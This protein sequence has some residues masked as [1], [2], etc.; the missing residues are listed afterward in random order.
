MSVFT[1]FTVLASI[2]SLAAAPASAAE[3]WGPQQE[4][5]S[6]PA[7]TAGDAVVAE[8]VGNDTFNR[9]MAQ[10]RA[11][12]RGAESDRLTN[13]IV[14]TVANAGVN[15]AGNAINRLI[16]GRRS[17]GSSFYSSNSNF[18]SG[19]RDNN[20]QSDTSR[21]EKRRNDTIQRIM[22]STPASWCKTTMEADVYVGGNYVSGDKQTAHRSCEER[23][24]EN[25]SG[26]F[27]PT[28]NTPAP[29]REIWGNPD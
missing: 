2:F 29:N 16:N 25:W 10:A 8:A 3:R 11:D 13:Q 12:K 17:Y 4:T 26:S 1:R 19:W 20:L 22:T 24:Q 15:V 21:C 5:S 14:G 9:C 6:R 27:R 7:Y 28:G 23:T 18:N